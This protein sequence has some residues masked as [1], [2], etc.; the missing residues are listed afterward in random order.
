M[1]SSEVATSDPPRGGGGRFWVREETP[2][3]GHGVWRSPY[4]TILAGCTASV[5]SIE[6]VEVRAAPS[7]GYGPSS[8]EVRSALH[9]GARPSRWTAT[10]S[11]LVVFIEVRGRRALADR[12]E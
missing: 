1:L 2:Q 7:R 3:S 5:K 8:R 10:M 4:G 6:L 9:A 12:G 11:D